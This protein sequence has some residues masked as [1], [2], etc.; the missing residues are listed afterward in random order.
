MS[1]YE[2]DSLSNTPSL[3]TAVLNYVISLSNLS[4]LVA[5]FLLCR[6]LNVKRTKRQVTTKIV[7]KSIYESHTSNTPCSN[8][9]SIIGAYLHFKS[10]LLYKTISTVRLPINGNSLVGVR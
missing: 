4:G 6:R 3:S 5:I 7:I 1:L 10:D 9:T 8:G 2:V